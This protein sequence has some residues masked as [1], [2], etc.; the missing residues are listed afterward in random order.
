MK[1]LFLIIIAA[2]FAALAAAAQDARVRSFEAA[3]MDVTAQKLARLDLHG[4]KCALVKVQVIATGLEFSGNVMGDVAKHGSEYWVYMTDG[5]KML[6]I[7]ADTFLPMMYYFPGPLR[8][9]VTYV[10]TLEAPYPFAPAPTTPAPAE[11]YAADIPVT[12]KYERFKDEASGKWGY[13][14]QS[15]AVVIPARYEDASNFNEGLAWVTI[16]GRRG[17]I[18]K[19]GTLV[20]P[21]RYDAAM[22][23]HEG[24]AAVKQ[25]GLYGFID[26]TGRL[27]I[28]AKY[29]DAL[30]FGDGLAA[31]KVY[32]KWGF[33]NKKDIFVIA[34]RYD[35][36]GAFSEG[37]CEVKINGK[38]GFI[39]RT[40]TLVLPAIYDSV[41]SSFRDG[42]ANVKLN[43]HWLFIDRSGNRVE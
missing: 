22:P 4:E 3:P 10:L 32:G 7:T 28:P 33:I 40:G 38:W 42:K 34:T 39:D 31:V 30:M 9:G 24:L 19:T 5:T 11:P 29:N 25:N 37:L 6:K 14:D 2:V 27:V 41:W 35:G 26:K 12:E 17:Y 43:G 15:G 23:F 13:K 18:D 16:N 21:A 20:I 8:G 1:R 36:A